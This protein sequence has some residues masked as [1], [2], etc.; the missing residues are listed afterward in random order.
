VLKDAP[1]RQR[2]STA[3]KLTAAGY[4]V[5]A[6]VDAYEQLLLSSR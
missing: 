3:A 2:L 4:G 1:L 6:M 5:D